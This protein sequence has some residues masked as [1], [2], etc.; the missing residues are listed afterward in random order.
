VSTNIA[1][2]NWRTKSQT[3]GVDS[4]FQLLAA[5]L[6]RRCLYVV[7]LGVF[8]LTINVNQCRFNG[9][10]FYIPDTILDRQWLWS[11][12]A[13]LIT[14]DWHVFCDPGSQITT[15]ELLWLG[16]SRPISVEEP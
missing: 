14:Q 4:R 8:N 15:I 7:K 16:D 13:A 9:D 3:T 6:Q 1:A 2:W 10:G 12:W 5:D 11:E